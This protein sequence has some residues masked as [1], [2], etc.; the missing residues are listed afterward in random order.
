MKKS[1]LIP[2]VLAPMAIPS[3]Q[4]KEQVRKDQT[5]KRPN[6]I[7]FLVDDMGWQ[8]TSL[9][10]WTRKTHYNEEFETPNMERLAA[11]GM[12]FT[13]AYASSISS[14]SRCSLLT[15]AN[16]AR[17]C[18][19][20]W[21]YPKNEQT[22]SPSS[23]FKVADWNVNGICEVPGI[24]HTFQVTALPELLKENGYHTIHCGKAHFGAVDTPGESPYHFG[25]EVNIAG[26][27][28]GGLASYLGED[29]YGNR[30]DGKPS[31]AFA[32]PGLEKYW[33][34]HTFVT[35]ALTLEAIKALDHAKEYNQPF[36]LY[37]AHYAIHIPID[38]DARYYQKYLDK[39]LSPKEAAYA[40]LIEGMDKSLG[41][42]MDW[43]DKNGETENTII[44]FMSDNGGLASQPD[45]RDGTPYTQNSP[46]KSGKG[47]A[48][49]GGI[50]EPMI[51]SWPGVVKPDTKCDKY[52]I[53]ED[54]FPTILEMAGVKHYST[55]QQ[56]DGKSIVPLLTQA[57][58]PS[59]GRSL[60]W[61]F[62]NN[63]GNT[64][65]GIGPTCTVRKGDW[66]LIYYYDT[67]KKE[68]FDIKED[69][70]EK[71]DLSLQHPD[72]V[73]RLSKDLGRYLRKVG[74]QRPT[75]KATGLPCPW[76]DE[77]DR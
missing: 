66:K 44:I 16:A 61:N 41:D 34:T 7:F 59:N 57:G 21:T 22:D 49:E 38:K 40:G 35:E 43:L 15:G 32:V 25:F 52:M 19:T 67:G 48:Y 4:G 55:V 29:N 65:P 39:G 45:W 10:F 74:G 75:F 77:I 50:R 30:T 73:K 42:L 31:P 47:S 14:P 2:F 23:V 9:P 71:N 28:G 62:P 20:N 76:P 13:Q 3:V 58:D 68:L 1:L 53:I 5:E 37:M 72:I 17:H 36:F 26:H 6:I 27:A 8:D 70:G 69:I 56:V 64:G 63:W 33:G 51:V 46:L 24:S 12:M 54:F 11:K 18:V 60:Y